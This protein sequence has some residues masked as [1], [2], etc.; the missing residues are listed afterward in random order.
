MQ[1]TRQKVTTV[2]HDPTQKTRCELT[3]IKRIAD[4]GCG[5]MEEEAKGGQCSTCQGASE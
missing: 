4:L 1:A 2:S 5:V 3:R